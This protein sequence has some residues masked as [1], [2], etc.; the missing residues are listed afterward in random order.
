[1]TVPRNSVQIDLN[2]AEGGNTGALGAVAAVDATLSMG[3]DT[4]LDAGLLFDGLIHW[5]IFER[6]LTDAEVAALY[7]SGAGVEPY[8]TPDTKLLSVGELSSGE[9]V[10]VQYPWVDNKLST[11]NQET[12]PAGEWISSNV[13][14]TNE[15]TIVKYDTQ[16]A[17]LDWVGDPS[18]AYAQN[19]TST[20]VDNQDYFY[21]FWVYVSTLHASDELHLDIVGNTIVLTRRLDT[22]ADDMGV[23]FATGKWLYFEGTFEADGGSSHQFRIRKLNA[24]GDA[25]VYIDQMDCQPSLVQNGYFGSDTDWDKSAGGTSTLTISGGTANFTYVDGTI[26]L[27]QVISSVT[28]DTWYMLNYEITAISGTPDLRLED[29]NIT[30]ASVILA[31]TVGKHIVLIKSASTGGNKKNL[32]FRTTGGTLSLDNINLIELDIVT[33]NAAS[34]ATPEI[35]SYSQEKFG[36]GLR[37]DGGDT[38]SWNLTGNK[39]EGSVIVWFKPMFGSDWVDDTNEPMIFELFANVSNYLKAYYDF[40]GDFWTFRKRV[41]SVNREAIFTSTHNAGDRICMVCTWGS[42]NGVQIYINGVAGA[43]HSNTDALLNNPNALNFVGNSEPNIPDAIY[44]EIYL[45]SRELSAAEALKYSNQSKPIKNNN[46]KISLTKT[47][48]DGDKL[49]IDSEKE[50]IEFADSTANTF[51]NAIASMDSGSFFPNMDSN[52]SVLF[53]KVA[54]AGIKLNYNKKWL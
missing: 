49:L 8:V 32:Q 1:M 5:Q 23:S 19:P 13:D 47:L 17:K 36:Q 48:S 11:G 46:A 27:S 41:A 39:N 51:T 4:G 45:L 6:A 18:G 12:N 3:Q 33:A 30:I 7:N 37:I 31:T 34:Q 25:T 52:K 44:D 26:R 9:P 35:V 50:T 24:N 2:A 21:R 29:G 42:M 40:T 22:G 28:D 38:L 16:S 15:T 10:S 14:I 43:A 54:N 20:L 53:N